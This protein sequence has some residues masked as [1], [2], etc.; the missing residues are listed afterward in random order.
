MAD[1]EAWVPML[2]SLVLDEDDD[3]DIDLKAEARVFFFTQD[4]PAE[5]CLAMVSGNPA[6]ARAAILKLLGKSK[7][8]QRAE[9]GAA[10]GGAAPEHASST[11]WQAAAARAPLGIGGDHDEPL[12]EE[13]WAAGGG[14]PQPHSPRAGATS[15][16]STSLGGALGSPAS[17]SS[18][19]SLRHDLVM[20]PQSAT[21]LWDGH[22]GIIYRSVFDGQEA[23]VK[24]TDAH[25][26][27]EL[28][29]RLQH[30][31]RV[32]MHLSPLAGGPVPGVI[33]WG[34]SLGQSLVF[35][36]TELVAGGVRLEDVE[37]S[38]QLPPGTADAAAA[39]L[40]AIHQH[41]VMHGDVHKGNILVV[42]GPPGAAAPA[43][44]VFVDFEHATV[45]KDARSEA[46]RAAFDQ[47]M[48]ELLT[49]FQ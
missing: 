35:M 45:F 14:R 18:L 39:A 48:H 46:A 29:A 10:A 6:V 13:A 34:R 37:H 26:E 27:L 24:A 43:R 42:P 1:C 20:H 7:C 49:L 40:A 15:T 21:V 47:E 12:C 32:L 33:G 9:G 17:A 41:G 16:A 44:V 23:A 36:A 38:T 2:D 30:E 4:A 5:R 3:R 11:G 25:K 22:G 8:G 28:V 31:M 19:G